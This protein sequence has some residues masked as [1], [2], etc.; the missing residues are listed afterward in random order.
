MYLQAQCTINSRV[1]L[2][3]CE[4]DVLGE[5]NGF[6]A[7]EGYFARQNKRVNLSFV[8]TAW[9]NLYKHALLLSSFNVLAEFST[10][11]LKIDLS[12]LQ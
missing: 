4:H 1:S 7:L 2:V 9:L 6:V 10:V 12:L 3:I 8:S 5:G 11:Y